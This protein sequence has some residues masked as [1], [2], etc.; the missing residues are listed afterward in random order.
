MKLIKCM[1]DLYKL[2]IL[3]VIESHRMAMHV[4]WDTYLIESSWIKDGE[5]DKAKIYIVE[6]V[7]D[8]LQL[9]DDEP[10]IVHAIAETE[11]D[12]DDYIYELHIASNGDYNVIVI[13][14]RE[15]IYDI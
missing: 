8:Y 14:K 10:I 12:I 15:F 4:I 13:G 3:D 7:E 9:M 2:P 5:Y 1:D 11:L 6:S